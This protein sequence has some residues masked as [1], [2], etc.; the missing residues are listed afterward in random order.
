MS[1]HPTPST[2]CQRCKIKSHVLQ[3]IK[4][5]LRPLFPP[6]V[7]TIVPAVAAL[8]T[9]YLTLEWEKVYYFLTFYFATQ[10]AQHSPSATQA[11]ALASPSVLKLIW[12]D[13]HKNSSR[14][15][16]HSIILMT[17][18]VW[19]KNLCTWDVGE[20]IYV[21]FLRAHLHYTICLHVVKGTAPTFLLQMFLC[22]LFILQ[23]R[24]LPVSI[25]PQSCSAPARLIVL[26][27]S[28]MFSHFSSCS[29]YFGAALLLVAYLDLQLNLEGPDESLAPS[30]VGDRLASLT[31]IIL[32]KSSIF[33]RLTLTFSCIYVWEE[34]TK[35][36][37]SQ[38]T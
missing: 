22:Q 30:A 11:E 24:A 27:K 19:W 12:E 34:N 35:G 3:N 36:S 5:H 37:M 14:W 23:R 18:W 7:M 13:K 38:I 28:S 32:A 29:S 6:W 4:V 17:F 1:R 21:V 15:N 20:R 26:P 25:C 9:R 8:L 33:S 2:E 10:A 16:E 31:K